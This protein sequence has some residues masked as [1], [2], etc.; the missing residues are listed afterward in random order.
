[1]VV[2][3]DSSTAEQMDDAAVALREAM[4]IYQAGKEGLLE[5]V[6]TGGK[7]ERCLN[8]CLVHTPNSRRGRASTGD[9]R[10]H[11]SE[12]HQVWEQAS[13]EAH[14]PKG[15]PGS[16]EPREGGYTFERVDAQLV[17]ALLGRA[18]NTSALGDDRISADIIR[19][20]WQWDKQRIINTISIRA[21]IRLGHHPELWKMAKGVVIPNPR[22]PDYSKVRA[23]RVVSLLKAALASLSSELPPT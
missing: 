20:F 10:R 4:A 22:K 11:H 23:Y 5:Q 21:C 18:A 6:P 14:L 19:T 13:L 8:C 3:D 9:R 1:M 7:G 16:Y 12:G 17:G 15:P 2:L